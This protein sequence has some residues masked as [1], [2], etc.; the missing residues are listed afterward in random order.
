MN[1]LSGESSPYLLQHAHNPVHWKPWGQ[2]AFDMAASENKPVLLSIGYSSCHWCHVMEKESFEDIE[3]ANL[4]NEYFVSIKVDREELPDVDHMYMDAVQAMTGSGG[5]P[6]H[7]FLTPDKKPFYGG[8]YFPKVRLQG[9]ASWKEVLQSVA[10]YYHSHFDEVVSQSEKLTRHLQE[11]AL[12]SLTTDASLGPNQEEHQAICTLMMK[13]MLAHADHQFGGF[14]H[15]PKF[16]ASFSLQYLI[17]YHCLTKDTESLQHVRLS[18]KCMQNGGLYDAVGGGFARYSTD[19]IWKVPHFEKMLYDNALLLELYSYAYLI[20]PDSAYESVVDQTFLWL[21]REMKGKEGMYY[22]A[23]DADSEGVE[24]KFYTWTFDELKQWIGEDME[25]FA[26]YYSIEEGGNWEHTNILFTT[27]EKMQAANPQFRNRLP[28]ILEKLYVERAK[29]I[30]PFTD[31]KI[32]LGWNALMNKAL[33]KAYLHTGKLHFLQEAIDHMNAMFDYLKHAEFLY[34]HSY[35]KHSSN[36]PAYLDDLAYLSDA[37]IELAKATGEQV[38]WK[39]ASD[40]VEHLDKHFTTEGQTYYSFTHHHYTRVS[41]NKQEIY[42]GALPSPNAVL[43][44]V[45][46]S[47]GITF[48]RSDWTKRSREMLLGMLTRMRTYPN[49][50]ARWVQQFLQINDAGISVT[51][52]GNQATK[53]YRQLYTMCKRPDIHFEV[54]TGESSGTGILGK[55]EESETLISICRD[56]VCYPP[57]R[58]VNSAFTEINSFQ[59]GSL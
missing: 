20:Q 6:L 52:T 50:F 39:E 37:L 51:I 14:G 11:S 26:S 25:S 10:G 19:D 46:Y 54:Q 56:F 43:C 22:S 58:D 24:G 45:L 41:V 33:V 36:I 1:E 31:R 28:A 47:L 15:A 21:T 27:A 9:R 30:W 38:Y 3:S 40:I 16:P 7:V 34:T 12:A 35:L 23:Q 48:Q 13:K 2:K 8:T 5:W 17:D 57:L 42:D 59:I 44:K 29:R 32:L 4:M 18:L 53:Y 55:N 49:S